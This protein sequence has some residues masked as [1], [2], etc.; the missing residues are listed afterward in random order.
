MTMVPD[1]EFLRYFD[2]FFQSSGNLV[3]CGSVAPKPFLE[4]SLAFI[5]TNNTSLGVNQEYTVTCLH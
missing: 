3:F 1:F 2:L 5:S 4:S